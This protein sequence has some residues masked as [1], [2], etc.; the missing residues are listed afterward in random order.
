[1]KK[2]ENVYSPKICMLLNFD[3]VK[4]LMYN[5]DSE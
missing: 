5:N 1:M 4:N 3:N 2:E